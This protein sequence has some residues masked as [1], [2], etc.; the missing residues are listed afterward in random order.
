L[1]PMVRAFGSGEDTAEEVERNHIHR[2]L[3]RTGWRIRGQG[4]AAEKL[5]LKPTTLE[6]RMRKLGIF[7]H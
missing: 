4:G 1:P 2:V 3:E 5:D 7:R 6:S